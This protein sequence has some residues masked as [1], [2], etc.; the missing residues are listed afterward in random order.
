MAEEKVDLGDLSSDDPKVKYGCAKNLLAI[1]RTNPS[2]LYSK[3]GDFAE[4]LDSENNIIKWTA[5]DVIGSLSRVD[6]NRR[7]DALMARL[8][9]FV[10]GGNLIT[11]NHAIAAL[12]NIALSKPEYRERITDELLKVEHYKYETS[13][14]HNIALGKVIM[15]LGSY[16][17]QPKARAEV[18]EFVRRQT[19]NT[20]NATKKKAENFLKQ[21]KIS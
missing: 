19:K 16:F 5:I 13:E 7:I 3:I 11:A 15:A 10:N 18:V 6:E 1:A 17:D 21:L 9:R 14:C 4:L 8:I 2:V 20:R 12:A